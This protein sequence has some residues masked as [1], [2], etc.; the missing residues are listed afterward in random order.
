MVVV[1]VER[2]SSVLL[3]LSRLTKSIALGP[4][5]KVLDLKIEKLEKCQFY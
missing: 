2:L 4:R 3:L 5:G 1:L